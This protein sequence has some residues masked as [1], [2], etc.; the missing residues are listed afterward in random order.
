MILISNEDFQALLSQ[1]AEYWDKLGKAEAI[2]A[3]QR[4]TLLEL[5]REIYGEEKEGF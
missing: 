5:F 4:K 1:R 3:E 2:I